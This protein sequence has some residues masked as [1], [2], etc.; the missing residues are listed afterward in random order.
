M[1][2]RRPGA[3]RAARG[4]FEDRRPPTWAWEL[5]PVDRLS[6]AASAEVHWARHKSYYGTQELLGSYR[7]FLDRP[8]GRLRP[9]EACCPAPG[10][11]LDDVTVV[12]DELA[13]VYR[14][15]PP[16]ARRALG[17]ILRRLDADFRH[18]TLPDPDPLPDH[19]V[20]WS[21]R[22]RSWWHRRLRAER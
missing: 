10:C 12:R 22:P 8:G 20:D 5:P 15:L 19:W 3:L 6:R 11:E 2:R 1:P 16:V 9:T 17:R 14:T 7:A 13:D 4:S 21:G 18:R